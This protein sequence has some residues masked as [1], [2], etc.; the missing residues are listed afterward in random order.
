[1]TTF[2]FMRN[3]MLERRRCRRRIREAM[4]RVPIPTENQA[5]IEKLGDRA[6]ENPFN[7]HCYNAT[8][9]ALILF[10]WKQ[11]FVPVRNFVPGRR[12]HYWLWHPRKNIHFDATGIIRSSRRL[13]KG[14][15]FRL[16]A[17]PRPNSRRKKEVKEIL[18]IVNSQKTRS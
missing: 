17:Y 10:G 12:G 2:Y 1:M 5:V 4:R 8:H 6:G 16:V 3:Q 9:S 11:H 18:R 13:K 15:D 14:R 7:G